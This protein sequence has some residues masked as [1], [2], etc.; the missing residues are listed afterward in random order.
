MRRAGLRV[1]DMALS[2]C[3]PAAI[4]SKHTS[5]T[6]VLDVLLCS[7][8]VEDAEAALRGEVEGL[9]GLVVFPKDGESNQAA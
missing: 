6:G 3:G 7:G 1:G 5:V 9:R 2:D 4:C 8:S